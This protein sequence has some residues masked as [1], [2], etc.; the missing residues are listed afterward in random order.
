MPVSFAE[1]NK[2]KKKK[3]PLICQKLMYIIETSKKIG[4]MMSV[5]SCFLGFLLLDVIE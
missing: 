4:R 5:N 1:A 3:K 2:R